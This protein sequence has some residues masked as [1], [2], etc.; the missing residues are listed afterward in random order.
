MHSYRKLVLQFSPPMQINTAQ[1]EYA[2]HACASYSGYF[3]EQYPGTPLGSVCVPLI[4]L[5]PSVCVVVIQHIQRPGVAIFNSRTKYRAKLI[6]STCAR[7]PSWLSF[8]IHAS[9]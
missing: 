2:K 9:K 5:L 4:H 6:T 3:L 8:G 1:K 7:F